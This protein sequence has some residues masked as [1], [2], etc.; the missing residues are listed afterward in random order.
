MRPVDYSLITEKRCSRCGEVK[1]ASEFGKYTDVN[2]LING[3]R[4]YSRCKP[5][6]HEASREYGVADRR[7]RNDRKS[8]WRRANTET[9]LAVEKRSRARYLY[10]ITP[11][12]IEYMFAA[13]DMLCAICTEAK[14]LVVDHD[15]QTGAVRGGLCFRCNN[16]LG[17]Y[18]RGH[19]RK[20]I[21]DVVAQ[22]MGTY[23]AKGPFEFPDGGPCHADALIEVVNEGGRP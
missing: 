5:C 15:H 6:A 23:I 4:Y 17:L 3:W 11:D 20:S 14:R 8:A 18:E 12:Q 22:A 19:R 21:T 2:H 9:A 1:P 13:Q 7:R 16:M 10:G